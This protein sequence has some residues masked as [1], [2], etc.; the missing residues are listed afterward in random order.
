MTRAPVKPATLSGRVNRASD[1]APIAGAAI[2]IAG[3]PHVWGESAPPTVVTSGSDGH[4]SASD[5]PSGCLVLT[6]TAVGF[7]PQARELVLA[8]G[9][10]RSNLDVALDAGGA[11]VTGTITTEE[12][13]PIANA[14]VRAYRDGHGPRLLAFSGADGRYQLSLA[15]GSFQLEV[16]HDDYRR[17]WE[18]VAPDDEPILGDFVLVRGGVIR[19]SIVA[20]DT[21]QP[22]PDAIVEAF[23]GRDASSAHAGSDGMFTLR[24]LHDGT[25][26]IFARGRGYASMT[27][28]TVV[29]DL[30]ERM[31]DVCVT[32]ACLHRRFEAIGAGHTTHAACLGL[33][34]GRR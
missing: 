2:A 17:A 23:G 8:E 10:E 24:G 15:P 14:R 5:V 21:G 11:L 13:Q 30:G 31:T 7:V 9:E 6:V 12:H 29:L 27:P 3:A 22:V 20:R 26:T 32:G 28:T 19:G 16:T 25:I 33:R 4:W 34:A 18:N 1:G